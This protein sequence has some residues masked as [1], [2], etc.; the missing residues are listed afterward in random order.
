[1]DEE[2]LYSGVIREGKSATVDNEPGAWKRAV[3]KL[4][5]SKAKESSDWRELSKTSTITSPKSSSTKNMTSPTT[6]AKKLSTN[7][8]NPQSRVTPLDS[9]ISAAKDKDTKVNKVASEGYLPAA[10]SLITAEATVNPNPQGQK[11]I[12]NTSAKISPPAPPN[13]SVTDIASKNDKES[14]LLTEEVATPSST[15]EKPSTS[16]SET[17]IS[18]NAAGNTTSEPN[19]TVQ[20]TTFKFNPNVQEFKPSFAPKPAPSQPPYTT[21]YPTADQHGA[22]PPYPFNQVPI[23]QQQQQ[24]I[25]MPYAMHGNIPMHSQHM[26]DP[27]M[28]NTDLAYVMRGQGYMQPQSNYFQMNGNPQLNGMP[29]AAANIAGAIPTMHINSSGH[30]AAG[31]YPQGFPQQPMPYHPSMVQQPPSMPLGPMYGTGPLPGPMQQYPNPPYIPN[32]NQ[33]AIPNQQ[34]SSIDGGRGR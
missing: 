16:V 24:G 10:T 19:K 27:G 18:S 33:R 31:V 5:V 32:P 22:N 25:H 4:P 15:S 20:K 9:N 14:K 7:N 3:Q 26:H 29:I 6:S 28:A 12:E 13:E 11:G 30:M 1:M 17:S 8:T 34:H 21:G 23:H 2:D